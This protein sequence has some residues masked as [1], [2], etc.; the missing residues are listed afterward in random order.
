MFDAV[1]AGDDGW[2]HDRWMFSLTYDCDNKP[3]V[4][5]AK[6]IDRDAMVVSLAE[7]SRRLL[8]PNGM[9]PS[10]QE[11]A[12]LAAACNQRLAQRMAY[13]AGKEPQP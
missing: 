6:A 5:W 13:G 8:E 11:L 1:M 10:N 12:D 2:K 7:L 3:T 9:F 4:P